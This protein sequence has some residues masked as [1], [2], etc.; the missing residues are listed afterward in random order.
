MLSICYDV[1]TACVVGSGGSWGPS[2]KG[3]VFGSSKPQVY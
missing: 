2:N 3:S 1:N